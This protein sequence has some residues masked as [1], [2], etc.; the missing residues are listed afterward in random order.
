MGVT[1]KII[2]WCD[3]KFNEATNE[4][5]EAKAYKKA[6]VSG[7]VEGFMDAAVV[8]YIPVVVACYIWKAKAEKK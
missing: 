4:P 5:N 1:R 2:N 6:F 7:A 8:L 3:N